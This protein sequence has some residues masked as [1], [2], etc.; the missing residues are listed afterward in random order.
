[1]RFL[2]A[3][4][5]IPAVVSFR[6]V[7]VSAGIACEVHHQSTTPAT[8][9]KAFH[10][11]LWIQKDEDYISASELLVARRSDTPLASKRAG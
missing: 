4:S 2:F 8:L 1:M 6:K 11:E 7:L 5:D 9:D 10:P 3:S